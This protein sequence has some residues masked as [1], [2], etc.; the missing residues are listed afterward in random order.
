MWCSR[1]SDLYW[2]RA[3]MLNRRLLIQLDRAKSTIR[4]IPPN[5][6]AGL[7]RSRVSG[8][9]RVPLPPANRTVSTLSTIFLLGTGDLGRLRDA[10]LGQGRGGLPAGDVRGDDEFQFDDPGQVH[11]VVLD[12]LDRPAGAEVPLL[13]HHLPGLR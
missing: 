12:L 5:G 7:A 10:Q 2:V 8:S 1:L 3:R 6:T 13:P 9:S 11:P 4:Y